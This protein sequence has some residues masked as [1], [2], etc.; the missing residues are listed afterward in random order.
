M[1]GRGD[2]TPRTAVEEPSAKEINRRRRRYIKLLRHLPQESQEFITDFGNI[3]SELDEY[4]RFR[5]DP[6]NL[7]DFKAQLEQIGL[8]EKPIRIVFNYFNLPLQGKEN[9]K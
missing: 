2:F 5:A 1:E 3:F 8:G 4:R 7:V 6:N 9:G